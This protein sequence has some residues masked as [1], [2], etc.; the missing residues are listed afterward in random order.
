M[1]GMTGVC[2]KEQM[3]EGEVLLRISAKYTIRVAI[4]PASGLR[5]QHQL[6]FSVQRQ[7][8]VYTIW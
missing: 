2:A 7:E 8:K 6:R 1:Y 4:S 5:I 3:N